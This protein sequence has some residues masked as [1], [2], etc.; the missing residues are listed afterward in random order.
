[1]AH[2][3]E[4]TLLAALHRDLVMSGLEPP[5]ACEPAAAGVQRLD[6][7][8]HL[9]QELHLGVDAAGRLVMAVPPDER[10]ACER[11][12]LAAELLEDLGEVK[13][14]RL[15]PLCV[16]VVRDELAELVLEDR[17]ATRLEPDDRDALAVPL[18]QLLQV[19]AQVA[20]GEVEEA[21][22]VERPAA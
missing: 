17:D 8:A 4:Q 12:R 1:L 3:R 7:D 13:D 18:L 14:A 22:V 11:R 5:R 6:L 19:P 9:L 2:P 20:L 21:V 10:L 15:Q 16:L